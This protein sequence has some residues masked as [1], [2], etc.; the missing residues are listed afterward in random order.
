[1]ILHLLEMT[2]AQTYFYWQQQVSSISLLTTEAKSDSILK[3][4]VSFQWPHFKKFVMLCGKYDVL[5]VMHAKL[6][7]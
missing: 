6:P 5:S 7:E 4:F 2:P 1:M 3:M